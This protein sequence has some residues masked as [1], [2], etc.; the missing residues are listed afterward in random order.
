VRL[1]LMFAT[2]NEYEELRRSGGYE[3]FQAGSYHSKRGHRI[4]LYPNGKVYMSCDLTGT[5]YNIATF[6]EGR[7]AKAD[8]AV[9]ELTVLK[10]H[11][12]ISDPSALLLGI[13]AN[14]LLR[15]SISYKQV[16]NL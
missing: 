11:P 7:F 5:D 8:T 14:G 13:Q 3:R 12:D 6:A 1:P 15:L 10:S 4:V 16:L 2:P 9:N